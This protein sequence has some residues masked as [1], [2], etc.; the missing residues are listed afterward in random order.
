[1]IQNFEEIVQNFTL[2]IEVPE[3]QSQNRTGLSI[4]PDH[5][6]YKPIAA[7]MFSPLEVF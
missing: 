3:R 7:G 1:M 4:I 5:M 6:L 2:T